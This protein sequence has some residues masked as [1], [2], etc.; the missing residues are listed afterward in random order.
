MTIFWSSLI[1]SGVLLRG[2]LMFAA[3]GE[4]QP[5]NLTNLHDFAGVSDG[6]TPAAGL[7]IGPSGALYGTTY[8]GGPS[9]SGTVFALDPPRTV[10]HAWTYKV[11]HEFTFGDGANPDAGILI[12]RDGKLYGTTYGGGVCSLSC[13]NGTVFSLTPTS[14]AGGTWTASVLHTFGG[15]STD[16]SNPTA[17]LVEDKAGILY[18][19]TNLGGTSNAGTVF[20]LTPPATRG[21]AWT[22]AVLHSFTGGNGGSDGA[23]P[24][25]GVLIG[26]GGVLYGTCFN[27]GTSN[28]GMVFSLTPPA[29]AGGTWT[30]NILYTFTGDSGSN[31]HASLLI[32]GSGVLYGTTFGGNGTIFSLS[33]PASPGGTWSQTVLYN[34][35]G[36]TDGA[37]PAYLTAGSG[38]VLY[39]TTQ[40]GGVG[41]CLGPTCGTVFS[42][43]PPASVGGAWSENVL[44]RFTGGIDGGTP[45]NAGGIAIGTHGAL[46]GTTSE[47]G[48][49][50]FGTVFKLSP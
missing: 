39:G 46:Y 20:S 21:G 42:L 7:V 40:A 5:P 27:G 1:A 37:A 3:G 24:Y 9:N 36:G 43:T 6:A 22:E 45:Y 38:G 34:F 41:S 23:N 31:P 8:G 10:G 44:H 29:S 19:T 13:N 35:A 26:K 2:L 30:E 50:G 14:S 15:F 12:G 4:A 25:A 17:G 49:Q 32:G 47:G 11:L 48:T 16:G 33:A 18:G 28:Y